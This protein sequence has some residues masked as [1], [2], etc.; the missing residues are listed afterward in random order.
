MSQE[1]NRIVQGRH[2][3]SSVARQH[4]LR[5]DGQNRL[6]EIPV[7]KPSYS[8]SA[9]LPAGR[10]QDRGASL[11]AAHIRGIVVLASPS[12]SRQWSGPWSLW[13]WLVCVTGII[14]RGML[15]SHHPLSPHHCRGLRKCQVWVADR[16]HQSTG[17][18][19]EKCRPTMGLTI[20]SRF[21]M[22]AATSAGWGALQPPP[23]DLQSVHCSAR[24]PRT[25][26]RAAQLGTDG[27]LRRS[28]FLCLFPLPLKSGCFLLGISLTEMLAPRQL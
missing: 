3:P 10:G 23:Q 6:G 20:P 17:R 15:L 19:F 13:V 14:P 26:G 1:G 7:K 4:L 16:L 21:Q 11:G 2:C 18:Q 9:R 12:S 24:V 27:S 5:R 22:F 25:G 28:A 8:R